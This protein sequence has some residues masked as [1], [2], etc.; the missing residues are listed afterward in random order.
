M[1]TS[2]WTSYD[3]SHSSAYSRPDQSHST[4]QTVLHLHSRIV[5]VL[6]IRLPLHWARYIPTTSSTKT[7]IAATFWSFERIGDSRQTPGRCSTPCARLLS[8]PS[9]FSLSTT[10]IP[11]PQCRLSTSTV[12]QRI[13]NSLDSRIDITDP[14]STCTVLA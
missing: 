9:T 7:L 2:R 11:R 10:S 6:H 8:A 5:S 3:P 1:R 4:T 14:S 13:Q 12:T